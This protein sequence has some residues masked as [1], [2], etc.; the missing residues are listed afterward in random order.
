MSAST[1][2]SSCWRCGSPPVRRYRARTGCCCASCPGSTVC[3]CRRASSSSW[4]SRSACWG[5]PAPPGFSAG[6]VRGPGYA[7]PS[8][9]VPRSFWRGTAGGCTRFRSGTT[10]GS[11]AR[12]NEWIRSGPPGGVLEL[13]IVGP[14][15]EPFTLA[16]Q[17]NTLLHGHPIVNGYSGYGYGLQD[18]L[19]GPGL[20]A[21][22]PGR[23]P[24]P[25]RR[26][27]GD[28]GPVHRAAPAAVLRSAGARMVGPE[29]SRR[30]D[31]RARR[32]GRGGR[33]TTPSAGSSALRG[34]ASR[35]TSRRWSP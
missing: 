20:A 7:R 31:R 25:A 10:S 28:R 27:A 18:F 16:Y 15:F 1:R 8:C 3:A 32:A 34:R 14:A 33:S 19:G 9:S 21:G 4:R 17:Y 11:R 30:T 2:P 6:L 26:P 29:G 35:S 24:R 22:R 5:R 12:L 13:P 23:A